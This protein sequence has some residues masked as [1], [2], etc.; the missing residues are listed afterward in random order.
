MLLADGGNDADWIRELAM[1]KGARAN[2]PPKSNRND[3]IC[4]RPNLYRA[5]NQ[6]EQFSTGSNNV[7]GC[8]R[9]PTSSPLTFVQLATM[10]CRALRLCALALQRPNA[11]RPEFVHNWEIHHL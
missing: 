5:R 2:I 10:A 8:H 11:L 1:K 6:V 7:V 3:P 4:F 9:V